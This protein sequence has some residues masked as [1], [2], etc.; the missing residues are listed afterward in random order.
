MQ[1]TNRRKTISTFIILAIVLLVPG[2]LY[3]ALNKVGSN[4][5]LKL[6][7]LGEKH[8]SG[9]MNRKMGREIPDTV[10][11]QIQPVELMDLSERTARFLGTDTVI[12]VV[13]T[14]YGSDEGLSVAMLESFKNVVQ[15]FKNNHKV[16][17]YSISIDST[18]TATKLSKFTARFR[19][20]LE[21]N[22]AVLFANRSILPYVQQ[23]LLSDAMV[24]P[25][26]SSRYI[27]SNQYI[28]IDS[29]R[30]IRGFYDIN[31]K[32]DIDRLEDEIKVQLVEEARNN[33]L[34][35]EKK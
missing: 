26:D 16:K 6:P 21:T 31:L 34:K 15:R 1:N 7:I 3:V 28:L 33:P 32:S 4:T 30:R 29:Q 18:D 19:Q 10:F 11:H 22:W 23:Q 8:L 2:F 9:K 24:D 5:Y 27:M 12:S 35:V 14:F 13:H 20:G 17:F 25:S